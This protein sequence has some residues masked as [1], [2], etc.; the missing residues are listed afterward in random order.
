MRHA[1]LVLAMVVSLWPVGAI[2]ASVMSGDSS[3]SSD[4]SYA[5]SDRTT[6]N[7]TTTEDSSTE[8]TPAPTPEAPSA[9]TTSPDGRTFRCVGSGLLADLHEADASITQAR[10]RLR[11]MKR[12]LRQLDRKYPGK[13]A[14]AAAADRY[15]YVVRTYNARLELDN[16]RVRAYNRKLERECTPD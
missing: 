15:N 14:P 10:K 4:S 8:S 2:A 1:L 3:T 7:D 16:K 6:T 5:G 13:A 12:E 11:A 9:V